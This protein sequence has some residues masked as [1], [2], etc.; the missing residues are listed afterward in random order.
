M[1]KLV[2]STEPAKPT[3]PIP[4]EQQTIRMRIEKAGRGGKT[5]TVADGLLGAKV[6][7]A[8]L[9]SALKKACGGGGALRASRTPEGTACFALEL[10]GDHIAKVADLLRSR[11]FR[12]KGA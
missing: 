5:V 7:A 6:D 8:T 2:W 9:L 10:Q 1:A 3:V 12:V 4:P 11:G